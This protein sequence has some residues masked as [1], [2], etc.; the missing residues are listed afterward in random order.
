MIARML[1]DESAKEA[2]DTV[3]AEEVE[4]YFEAHREEFHKS[5]A[6]SVREIV[7][8][9]RARA[10]A[11]ANEARAIKRPDY[12]A[13]QRAFE[14]LAARIGTGLGKPAG[15]ESGFFEES[16]SPYPR[17]VTKAIFAM[18]ELGEVIGPVEGGGSYRVIKLAGRRPEVS[19]R[20]DEAREQIRQQSLARSR[21]RRADSFVT[22]ILKRTPIQID[23][24]ALDRVS[25]HSSSTGGSKTP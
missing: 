6:M 24:A 2:G 20:I 1:Q 7:I 13:D 11:V 17:E 25:W 8:R 15:F 4:R 14:Q 5:A 22:E 12:A 9:D 3:T 16:S 23:E 18:T 10:D 21:K 19:R